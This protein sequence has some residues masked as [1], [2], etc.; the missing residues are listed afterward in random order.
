MVWRNFEMGAEIKESCLFYINIIMGSCE[1]N[2]Y[3]DFSGFLSISVTEW[4]RLEWTM[5]RCLELFIA[6]NREFKSNNVC[7]FFFFLHKKKFIAF[8]RGTKNLQWTKILCVYVG[9]LFFILFQKH[10]ANDVRKLFMVAW[11]TERI[12]PSS[13]IK[14]RYSH[15]IARMYVTTELSKNHPTEN[16]K[17]ETNTIVAIGRF[18]SSKVIS[19]E[20][21]IV[22]R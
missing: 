15:A 12:C 14:R 1:Q 10:W 20:L 19:I 2:R 13:S 4:L 5:Y 18:S 7:F 22:N 6:C 17:K 8:I 21:K 11:L 3:T 16:K 9:G